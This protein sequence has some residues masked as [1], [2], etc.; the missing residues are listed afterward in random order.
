M[1]LGYSLLLGEHISAQS[2]EYS[3]CKTFQIV[4]PSCKEPI[5]K[6]FRALPHPGIHYLSH[7]EK[8]KAYAADCEL[9]VASIG[10]TDVETGNAA[11]RG[12]RLEYFLSVLRNA[13]LDVTNRI[14]QW[15]RDEA[16]K[17]IKAI[18]SSSGPQRMKDAIVENLAEEA[19]SPEILEYRID[20]AFKFWTDR[21][22][23]LSTGFAVNTQRRIV[24]DVFLHLLTAK[25]QG[26]ISFLFGAAYMSVMDG[27]VRALEAGNPKSSDWELLFGAMGSL[28]GAGRQKAGQLMYGLQ[29]MSAPGGHWLNV[30]VNH[31]KNEMV[32]LLWVVP[33]FELLKGFRA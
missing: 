21:G 2:I 30:I 5:F 27:A 1:K 31:I 23:N 25:A 33:Y 22:F 18:M 19:R 10:T 6:A 13:I 11:S 24:K 4:C 32:F 16:E 28:I 29:S 9:R 3:D 8:E 12:Q 20:Y 14:T 15:P 7:Y 26:N 17:K